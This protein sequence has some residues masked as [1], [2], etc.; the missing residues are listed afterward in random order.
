MIYLVN[1]M[2]L[3]ININN[4][5]KVSCIY[6]FSRLVCHIISHLHLNHSKININYVTKVIFDVITNLNFQKIIRFF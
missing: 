3:I 6:S 2:K 4:F 1:H 5:S